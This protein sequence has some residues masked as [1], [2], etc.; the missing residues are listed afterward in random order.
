MNVFSVVKDNVTAR[1]IKNIRVDFG[2]SLNFLFI[3]CPV[4]KYVYYI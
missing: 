1:A 2:I 3:K 4:Y